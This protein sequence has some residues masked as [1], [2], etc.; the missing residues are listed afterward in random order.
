MNNLA[1]VIPDSW[2]VFPGG[3]GQG[4]AYGLQRHSD[5]FK[6]FGLIWVNGTFTPGPR[7]T[8][9]NYYGH[10]RYSHTLN[11]LPATNPDFFQIIDYAMNQAIGVT[12]P[13]HVRNTFNVA[14]ALVD[15][16][17][18]DDLVDP[19]PGQSPPPG[20]SLLGNTITI[21]D[22]DGNPANY[23]YGMEGM[24]FDDPNNNP[25]R[26][27]FA[28]TPPPQYALLNRRFENVGEFGYA[29][30]PA[31][32][33]TSKTLDFASSA[34]H[35]RALLD[36][37]TYNSAGGRAGIVNLNTRMHLFWHRLFAARGYVIPAPKFYHQ[38]LRYLLPQ[39]TP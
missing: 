32:T 38:T 26:P 39:A 30:N 6:L 21:I 36:F 28:P 29:Y 7:M 31:S 22:Y 12:D 19:T 15:Q 16:Y 8:D 17:D 35:D 33:T 1:L 2:R 23:A 18:T 27:P 3:H 5:F 14:A 34:S 20:Q 9:P 13:N 10:W 24:S 4:H 37:V 25:N 11:P